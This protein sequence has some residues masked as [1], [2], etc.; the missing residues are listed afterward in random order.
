MFCSRKRNKLK[1]PINVARNVARTAAATHFVFP[2]DIELYPNPGLIDD[3]LAMIRR[4]DPEIRN[5]AQ[6]RV[7]VIPPFEIR[8]NATRPKS[9]AE[10]TR[11]L[12]AKSAVPFHRDVCREC[13]AIP[14]ADQWKDD[15]YDGIL[16][17]F[18]VAK[19]TG[20]HKHW[21][22]FYIGTNRDPLYDESLSWEGR[23]DKMVQGYLLCALNYDFHVLNGA[24][25][26]H[27]PGI[28]T[29]QEAKKK[30]KGYLIADQNY[31]IRK[32]IIPQMKKLFNASDECVR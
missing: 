21:E 13:H 31:R 9:K 25:L 23:S 28:K 12:R 10:L 22:P 11:M 20:A 30:S 4:N 6:P 32:E 16:R 17:T 24:Y 14:G 7:F 3:F 5:R 8:S 18:R 15:P 19:R 29:L 26:I 1:Y 2:A 27:K